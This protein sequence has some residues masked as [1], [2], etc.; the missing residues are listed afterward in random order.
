MSFYAVYFVLSSHISENLDTKD[1]KLKYNPA[2]WGVWVAQSVEHPTS[3]RV[4][5]SWFVSL[6]PASG[7][8]L[9]VPSLEP[10]LV[11]VSPPLSAPPCSR[12]VSLSFS[13]SQ[14]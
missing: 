13:L 4:M 8:V 7:S 9:T 10:A 11:S 6:S 5:I 3:A 14:K 12:S 1:K 2:F